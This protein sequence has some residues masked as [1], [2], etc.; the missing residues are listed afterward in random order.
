MGEKIYYGSVDIVNIR[1][2]EVITLCEQVYKASGT[3]GQVCGKFLRRLPERE[4]EN[5]K[6]KRF[7]F[8]ESKVVGVSVI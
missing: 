1:T 7:R 6:I 5:Y 8:D 2:G 3:I 4:R